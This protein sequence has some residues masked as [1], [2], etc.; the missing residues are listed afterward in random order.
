[1]FF[2]WRCALL[3][4]SQPCRQAST[5][6]RRSLKPQ[7]VLAPPGRFLAGP[8]SSAEIIAAIFHLT[9]CAALV[10]EDW[11]PD[12]SAYA[13]AWTGGTTRNHKGLWQEFLA[14]EALTDQTLQDQ[15][16]VLHK[17]GPPPGYLRTLLG[18]QCIDNL[19][20]LWENFLNY[21]REKTNSTALVRVQICNTTDADLQGWM[22]E[23]TL[24]L[25]ILSTCPSELSVLQVGLR[26]R[27][28]E[29]VLQADSTTGTLQLVMK[30]HTWPWRSHLNGWM[31]GY[32]SVDGQPSQKGDGSFMRWTSPFVPADLASWLNTLHN[33]HLQLT[34]TGSMEAAVM[35]QLHACR[36]LHLRC[37]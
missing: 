26:E 8:A 11:S 29:L 35:E 37:T 10:M 6:K 36:Y 14:H 33:T 18:S 31:S 23:T 19:L 24:E 7:K 3:L 4:R 27:R 34:I 25:T 13:L 5:P 17:I 16:L 30:G 21:Q 9:D 28:A 15:F 12:A 22:N 20:A 1:M 32:V 2:L